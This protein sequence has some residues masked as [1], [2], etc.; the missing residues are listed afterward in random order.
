MFISFI[1]ILLQS[2]I[3]SYNLILRDNFWNSL[4]EI[5]DVVFACYLVEYRYKH[6]VLHD[7]Y[8]IAKFGLLFKG[9]IAQQQQKMMCLNDITRR[10]G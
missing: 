10:T 3:K 2:I 6:M 7:F 1:V 4:Q 9:A 5:F 8:C